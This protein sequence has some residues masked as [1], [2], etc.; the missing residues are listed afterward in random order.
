MRRW[1]TP[2]AKTSISHAR[3]VYS[4]GGRFRKR[5]HHHALTRAMRVPLSNVMVKAETMPSRAR[6]A[7][8]LVQQNPAHSRVVDSR[9]DDFDLRSQ[10]AMPAALQ[11]EEL[12]ELQGRLIN[13]WEKGRIDKSSQG[14][15]LTNGNSCQQVLNRCN[16]RSCRIPYCGLFCQPPASQANSAAA[17]AS[18]DGVQSRHQ[19]TRLSS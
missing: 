5:D 10:T 16:S 7:R 11:I 17:K 2:P 4:R 3:D 1:R 13:T 15:H 14:Q 18:V 12:Q 8:K 9:P 19:P 6:C